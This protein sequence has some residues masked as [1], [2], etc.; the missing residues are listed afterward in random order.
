MEGYWVVLINSFLKGSHVYLLQQSLGVSWA[1]HLLLHKVLC[2][3]KAVVLTSCVCTRHVTIPSAPVGPITNA[4][5]TLAPANMLNPDSKPH[6][7]LPKFSR[8]LHSTESMENS[9]SEGL[10]LCL[11]LHQKVRKQSRRNWREINWPAIRVG[12]VRHLSFQ[13]KREQPQQT[14]SPWWCDAD[15]K[16]A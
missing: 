13:P 8:H 15:L 6:I 14:A 12:C 9:A 1:N 7:P 2:S 4:F 10:T 11:G 5:I 3:T 16:Q